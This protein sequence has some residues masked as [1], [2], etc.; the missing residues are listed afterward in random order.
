MNEHG[1]PQPVADVGSGQ[2]ANRGITIC[3]VVGL[4]LGI[5]AVMGTRANGKK[6]GR[7]LA[8]VGLVISVV[9]VA[10]VLALQAQWAAMLS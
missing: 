2:R 6:S 7:A 9:S 5:I 10:I 1:T 8:V 4:I 3:G